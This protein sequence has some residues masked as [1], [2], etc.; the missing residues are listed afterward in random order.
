L[1]AHTTVVFCAIDS[2]ISLSN[3][4]LTGFPEFLETL[5]DGGVPCV[6]VTARNRMQLDASLRKFGQTAPFIAENGSGVYLPEDYFHLRPAK[7]VRLGRFTCIPVAKEPPA[8]KDALDSLA[9]EL[10]ISVVPLRTLSPRELSQNVGLPQREAELLRQRDFDELFFFAGAR[11][12]EIEKFRSEAEARNLI[13]H[14]Q[15]ALWSLAAGAAM[16][17]CV[18]DLSKLYDRATHGHALTI[19]MGTEEDA[20][21]LF[22]HCSRSLVLKVRS[23]SRDEVASEQRE[24]GRKAIP[25]FAADTWDLALEAIQAGRPR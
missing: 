15:D 22:P 2:L 21:E 13:L 3:K 25:L 18:R 23:A 1:R 20:T 12:E 4:A 7:T 17:K 6:W 9:E 19:A 5:S 10:E 16:G 14:S 11:D 8:A 24:P